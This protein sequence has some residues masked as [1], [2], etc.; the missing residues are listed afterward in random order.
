MKKS[1]PFSLL[2]EI[3]LLI[4]NI[5]ILKKC[6]SFFAFFDW[7]FVFLNERLIIKFWFVF[8]I[9]RLLNSYTL[10]ILSSPSTLSSWYDHSFIPK[11]THVVL[12]VCN[13]FFIFFL[14]LILILHVF[15]LLHA[16]NNGISKDYP[17][18]VNLLKNPIQ[19]VVYFIT[20]I[21]EQKEII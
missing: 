8:E 11:S 14:Q 5:Y 10:Q 2:F 16:W 18:Q 7:N 9:P 4:K 17:F 21:W 1:N 19:Q 13:A 12:L 15:I 6:I 20:R 3:D